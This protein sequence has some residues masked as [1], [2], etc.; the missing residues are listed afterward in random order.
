M[1]SLEG[2]LYLR[3]NHWQL[4]LND[5]NQRSMEE[6]CG[7]VAGVYQTSCAVYPVTNV[8]HSP[9]RYRMDPEQQLKYFNQIDEN[10]WQLLAIYHSHLQGPRGPSQLDIAEAAYP[11]VIYLIWSPTNGEWECQGYL[12]EEGRVVQ[13]SVNLVEEDIDNP[14]D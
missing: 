13:V 10:H 5:I 2:K 14:P 4:M 8:L 11:G 9:V 1:D 12:I 7:L 6:A 3:K